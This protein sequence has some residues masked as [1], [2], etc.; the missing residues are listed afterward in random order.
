MPINEAQTSYAEE[1][2]KSLR[3]TDI[4]ASLDASSE[5]INARIRDHELMKVPIMFVVGGKEAEARSVSIRRHGK[6]NVGT[7]PLDEALAMIRQ[8]CAIPD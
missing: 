1:I 7:V 2:V 3:G 8:E 6:G 4:R 5:K